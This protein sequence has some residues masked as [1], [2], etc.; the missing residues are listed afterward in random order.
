MQSRPKPLNPARV[1]VLGF[2][3]FIL[4]GSL[5]LLLP[6]MTYGQGISYIDAFFTATSAVCVTG[7]IVV[8][9]GTYF[10]PIGQGVIMLLIFCGSLGFMTM[11]TLTFVF[12]GRKITLRDRLLVKE[13]F[14][15]NSVG[16]L[17]RLVLSVVRLA[18][19]FIFIGTVAM[20]FRFVPHYGWSRGMFMSIFHAVSAFGNAG[21]D[22]FG[23]FVSLTN[24]PT[25]YLV[26]GTILVL[27]VIGGLGFTVIL[28]LVRKVRFRERISLHT[29]L[30]LL[31][32]AVLLI[33]GTLTMLGLEY[34]NSATMG[35]LTWGGKIFTALFTAATPRT[36]G[37]S[38]LD[39]AGI[40]YPT[41]LI[42]L[43]LMFIG[44][45]PASTG[46][47][48]KTTTFGVVFF[49]LVNMIRGRQKPV[50][51][52]R[53]FAPEQIMKAVSIMSAAVGLIF[54]ATFSMTFFEDF[55]FSALLFEAFSA[56]GTVGLSRGI[57][58]DLSVPSKI[59]IILTMFGGRVGPL[60]LLIALTRQQKSDVLQYPEEHILI[61]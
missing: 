23:D 48:I 8:D 7:L 9:T 27:F 36:A 39:T 59:T 57:T 44:A 61:G 22:L 56:F 46:G 35:E 6:V 54:L 14:N 53:V 24:N 60:T 40:T 43:A 37:F 20:A 29:R 38:V 52:S 10:T 19:F 18:L 31:V 5:L 55:E 2:C 26:N 21:F 49:T 58:P 32:T 15:Q 3:G 45:S 11:A 51:F 28:E 25:D 13:A 33:G 30:A 17:V 50:V 47:G 41:L 4:L 34:S 12:L 16:G 42:L 1:L